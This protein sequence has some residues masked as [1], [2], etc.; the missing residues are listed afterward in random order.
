[1]SKSSSEQRLDAL[2]LRTVNR[3]IDFLTKSPA[4]GRAERK[5]TPKNNVPVKLKAQSLLVH[6]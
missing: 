5:Y 6:F 2:V 1:M 4:G 3:S